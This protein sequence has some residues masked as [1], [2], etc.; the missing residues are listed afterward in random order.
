MP[1]IFWTWEAWLAEALAN[2]RRSVPTG[3]QLSFDFPDSDGRYLINEYKI[4]IEDDL[5]AT[6]TP[7]YELKYI[8]INLTLKVD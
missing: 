1:G 3:C 4:K 5:T 2:K 7:P 8:Q 6:V